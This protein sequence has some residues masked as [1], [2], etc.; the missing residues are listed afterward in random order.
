[1]H[2]KSQL[3]KWALNLNLFPSIVDNLGWTPF[4]SWFYETAFRSWWQLNGLV[5]VPLYR[6]YKRKKDWKSGGPIEPTME[7]ESAG[8]KQIDTLSIGELHEIQGLN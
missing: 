8:D 2:V 6:I 4:Q 7:P 5:G 1:M 3:S